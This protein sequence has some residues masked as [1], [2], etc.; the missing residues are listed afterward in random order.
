M[1]KDKAKINY[2][3]YTLLA[4]VFYSIKVFLFNIR[5][6]FKHRLDRVKFT[7]AG[8]KLERL[9]DDNGWSVHKIID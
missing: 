3:L 5:Y 4:T 1:S 9:N 6:L 8:L 2:C 7:P